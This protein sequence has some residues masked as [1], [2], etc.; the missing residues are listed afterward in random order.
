MKLLGVEAIDIAGVANGVYSF[1]NRSG[2]AHDRVLIRGGPGTGKTRL[3]QLILAAREVLSSGI[4]DH[5]QNSFIRPENKTAKVILSWQLN[6]EEQAMIASPTPVVTT[7]VI[8]SNE[9]DEDPVDERMCFLLERYGHDDATPKFEYFSA[10]RRL[11][12]GG[13]E[14]G[15]GEEEQFGMRADPSPRKFAWVPVFLDHLPDEPAKAARFSESLAR[16]SPTCAYDLGRHVLT[17]RGRVL[18]SLAELSASEADA[19]MFSA[20]AAL[21]GLSG[22]IVLV[23]GPELHG[24][25]AER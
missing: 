9:E 11:D 14:I 25:H 3:L 13:G 8:F 23:D 17:S 16:F 24:I 22:S 2:Q 20:T 4:R 12:V 6:A 18:K 21:V 15:L 5:Q 1:A 10:R 19:V 7:E